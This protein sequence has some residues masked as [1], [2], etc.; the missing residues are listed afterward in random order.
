MGCAAGGEGAGACADALRVKINEAH[1]TKMQRQARARAAT[2]TT[3]LKRKRQPTGFEALCRRN[4]STTE[5]R[6]SSS[7]KRRLAQSFAKTSSTEGPNA[8]HFG[9]A[10]FLQTLART[11]HQ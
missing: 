10:I 4:Y 1:R 6:L 3:F 8:S 11:E 9:K 2:G 7:L 5:S